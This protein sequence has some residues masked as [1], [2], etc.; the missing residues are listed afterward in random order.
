MALYN[1]TSKEVFET[2]LL[3][4]NISDS[5]I[6]NSNLD[7]LQCSDTIWSKTDMNDSN[8]ND[9]VFNNAKFTECTF[10]RSSLINSN[11]QNC[12]FINSKFS[13]ISFI[14]IKFINSRLRNQLF[15]S[16]TMQRACLNKVIIQNSTLKD[17]EAVYANFSNIVFMN[18][19]FEINYGSGS[20]GLSSA[21]L[22]D[23]IFLNCN[24]KGY[25]L[26]GSNLVNCTFINCA[27]EI[28]DDANTQNT[29][30]LPHFHTAKTISLNNK[31][32]ANRLISEVKNG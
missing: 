3:S 30:G 18:C 26:R 29:Y 13:G 19:N 15:D 8:C 7:E 12:N 23:C 16:C 22:N 4:K 1:Y 14:K 32:Q 20:N 21:N 5:S 27:G 17:F 10:F 11:F 2:E 6:L 31:Q 9:A 24:F 25:P 28:T